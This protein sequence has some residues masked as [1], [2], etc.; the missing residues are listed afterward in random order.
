MIP[1]ALAERLGLLQVCSP[2]ADP[3]DAR[4]KALR[5]SRTAAKAR[6]AAR[7]AAVYTGV[8]RLRPAAPVLAML[9][10]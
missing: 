9:V 1:L 10:R 4:R 8:R 6:E 3:G 5:V 2:S 7:V